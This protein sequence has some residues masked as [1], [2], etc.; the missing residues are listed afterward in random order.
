MIDLSDLEGYSTN[1]ILARALIEISNQ[2]E[3]IR[4][5]FQNQKKDID[6]SLKIME[7]GFDQATTERQQK[8]RKKARKAE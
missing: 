7:A 6:R 2:L 3:G 8:P 5:I 4:K 1:E